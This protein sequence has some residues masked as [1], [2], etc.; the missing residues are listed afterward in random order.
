M[1]NHFAVQYFMVDYFAQCIGAHLVIYQKQK[2]GPLQVPPTPGCR[3]H[4]CHPQGEHQDAAKTQ[5]LRKPGRSFDGDV[6]GFM[7]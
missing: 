5:M 4:W 6:P 2:P 3:G 7:Q 1:Y